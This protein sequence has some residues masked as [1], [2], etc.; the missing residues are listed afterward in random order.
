MKKGILIAVCLAAA[1]CRTYPL[2]EASPL[3]GASDHRI[4]RP[5]IPQINESGLFHLSCTD[6]YPNG[7]SVYE[8]FD[9]DNRT[10]AGRAE[11]ARRHYLHAA[12]ANNVYRTP[13]TKPI[14]VIPDWHLLESKQSQSGFGVEVYGD[15]A[16]IV[17]SSRI[18]IAYRGTDFTS[19]ADWGNNI[20]LREPAQYKE[21]YTHLK[22]LKA[23]N[24][25]AKFITSGHSLGGGIALNMSLRF[26]GVDAVAFN[27]SP[28]I[29]FGRTS[30]KRENSRTYLYEVGEG[31][32][33]AFGQWSRVRLP[34]DTRY[35]NYNFLD[36]KTLSFSPVQ[37]HGIYEFT[38][39][40]LLVAMT[41]DQPHAR[42]MFAANI[43]AATALQSDPDN[44]T[45]IF[46]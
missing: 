40:L 46:R 9:Q 5:Y 32:N 18:V 39:G 23:S 28:R 42:R 25:S 34:S 45:D 1:G 20:A 29:Y 15:R 14:F 16:T 4:V 19:Y 26:D 36:Y 21:A 35:G 44:C 38:R 7:V 8:A 43:D 6:R 22:A 24:K 30:S 33:S 10:E 11:L 13:S 17:D 2:T 37:E 31:L 41:R 12:M 3:S 27:P